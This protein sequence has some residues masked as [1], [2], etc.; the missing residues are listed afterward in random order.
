MG[1]DK[2]FLRTKLGLNENCH[3][4]AI[5]VHFPSFRNVAT[6]QRNQSYDLEFCIYAQPIFRT[7]YVIINGV[8]ES[9]PSPRRAK[10]I[11]WAKK[12]GDRTS[13]HSCCTFT[14]LLYKDQDLYMSAMCLCKDQEV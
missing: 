12:F 4:T 14:F 1:G 7:S 3:H 10:K 5:S 9:S 11:T 6:S 8:S 13:L 2:S